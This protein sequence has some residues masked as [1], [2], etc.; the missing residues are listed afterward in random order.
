MPF[1]YKIYFQIEKFLLI[2]IS[3]DRGVYP[4]KYEKQAQGLNY[5]VYSIKISLK[6]NISFWG[7]AKLILIIISLVE[8]FYNH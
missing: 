1:I 6:A 3:A 7:Q 8:K 4:F 2:K 5:K